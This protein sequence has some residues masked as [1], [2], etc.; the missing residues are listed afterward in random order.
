MSITKENDL[1]LP[2][3]PARSNLNK[4]FLLPGGRWSWW[5]SNNT[6]RCYNCTA[7]LRHCLWESL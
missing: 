6:Y 4:G 3:I 7:Q 2:L 1:D 5:T